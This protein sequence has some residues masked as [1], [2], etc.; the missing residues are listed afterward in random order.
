M[1]AKMFTRLLGRKE[2]QGKPYFLSV[3]A[4]FKNEAHIFDEWISHHMLHGVEHFYLVDN[5]STDAINEV[6]K[7]YIA[8]GIVTLARDERKYAQM[9]IYNE[10]ILPLA[11]K[12]S[13]WLAIID[14]DEF[15]YARNGQKITDILQKHP[16]TV[17]IVAPWLEFGTNGNI[18]QPKSVVQSCV[19][20]KA[21]TETT[22]IE[23]KTVVRTHAVKALKIHHHKYHFMRG[24]TGRGLL[25][26]FGK[27]WRILTKMS[28]ML[29]DEKWIEQHKGLVINHYLLQS[30]EFFRNVKMVRGDL[31]CQGDDH[32]RD[33]RYFRERNRNEVE[34]RTLALLNANQKC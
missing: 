23:V 33:M 22:C 1:R 18:A 13:E 6:L 9:A 19:K 5:G 28:F 10:Q 2:K 29:I 4:I 21:Y 8:R 14:L 26:F 16:F 34:D 12:E 3:G 30:L 24:A 32:T 27:H 7:P 20:R 11:K 15:L 17:G 25:R 31:S